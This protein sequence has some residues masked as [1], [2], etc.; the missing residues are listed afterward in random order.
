[1]PPLLKETRYK[2]RNRKYS[3]NI[4]NLVL[5]MMLWQGIS[6]SAF[7]HE[8]V[9]HTGSG[10]SE[11]PELPDCQI[12]AA[13]RLFDGINFPQENM[14]VLIEGNTIKQ[15]DSLTKLNG[16]CVN[17]INLGDATI[18][19]GFIESHA[20]IRFQNV[21]KNIVLEHGITTV[22]ETGGPL[23]ASE[24]GQGTL[25]LFS[26]GPIIQAVGG[27]PLNIFG[28]GDGGYDKIG[29]HVA[30]ITEAE[31]V[32]TTLVAGGAT[33]IKIALEPG[34][35]MGAPWMQP[36]A[37]VLPPPTPWP[38][39]SQDITNAI[40]AKAHEL[41]KRVLVHVGE[42]TGFERA[43]NAGVDEFAHIPCAEIDED[44]L[45]RA[46]DQGVTFVTTIDTLSSCVNSA[47]QKGIHSNTVSLA[48]KGAKFI[49][50]SE[51]GHDNVP[52][53]INGEELHQILH[54]TSGESIDFADVVNV[55]KSVTSKAG[56]HLRLAPLGTLTPGAPADVIAVRGNPFEKFKILEYPD[57]VISG[58]R[59]IVNK[60]INQLSAT[61]LECFFA[62]AEGT[63]PNE[64]AP[65]GASTE[66]SNAYSYRYYSSTN[67][68]L[69]VSS[70]DNHV[71]YMKAEDG[72]LQNAGPLSNWLPVSGCQ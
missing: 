25:R 68:Y 15:V 66:V 9:D 24:G 45:Q 11:V 20:H 60:F 10:T 33:A 69:G 2:M 41:G 38:I 63:Y 31:E 16:L 13:T 43:L 62:W 58:G 56:E 14:A 28:G 5:S 12:L 42:N 49:Y 34:G 32:V 8:G 3:I 17:Q 54:L 19:P 18:L 6:L 36:H 53:G 39:L 61:T 59:T 1:M 55:F 48:S 27:Y 57:L 4:K 35:E 44:L 29:I 70:A 51:I 67:T 26:V 40:V 37:G 21:D 23:F 47:T 65:T 30:S 22:Q 64:L 7:S 50:G 46:V 52:W 72:L 71:Y